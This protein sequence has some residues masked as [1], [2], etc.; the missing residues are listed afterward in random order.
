MIGHRCS[1]VLLRIFLTCLFCGIGYGLMQLPARVMTYRQEAGDVVQAKR[2][3]QK[4]GVPATEAFSG[5]VNTRQA[6]S[7]NRGETVK[8]TP[9]NARGPQQVIE[10]DP[11][12]QALKTVID[13]ELDINIVDLGLIRHIED[14]VDEGLTITM[15]PTSPLCPYLKHLVADIKKTLAEHTSY[16][17]IRVTIDMQQRWTP[18]YLSAEGQRHF[19][20]GKP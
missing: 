7:D 19:F 16:R 14:H 3:T 10:E 20:G 4:T 13:P 6:P 2:T 1:S 12:I 11:V 9:R 8:E 18:A 15:I 5:A 17:E